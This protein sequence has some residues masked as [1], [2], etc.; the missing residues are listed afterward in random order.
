MLKKVIIPSIWGGIVLFVWTI[1]INGF[2]GFNSRMNMNRVQNETHVYEILK[3]NIEEPGR[4][5]VNPQITSERRFPEGE[6]V[7][8]VLYG[9][10]GHEA[11]GWIMLVQF[12]IF[13]LAPFIGTLL[14]S[15]TSDKFLKSYWR[16]VL[17]FTGI[18]LIIALFTDLNNFGIGECPFID[19]LIFAAHDILVWTVVGIV[20]AWRIKPFKD[21]STES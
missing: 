8:S 14:L 11:A 12:P 16:K 17:Y 19:A 3:E 15:F 9:G 1:L 7:F 10:L 21:I 18:G 6:P 5:S 20:V 13:F 4:Y 2:L